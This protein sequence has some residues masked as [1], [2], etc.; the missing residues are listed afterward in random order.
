MLSVFMY[1]M[2]LSVSIME[3]FKKEVTKI[4]D[5]ITSTNKMLQQHVTSLKRS[6][7][8]LIKNCEEN[9]H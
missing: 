7:E 9:E 1:T 2:K 3:K 6:N 4:M 8:D 5:E